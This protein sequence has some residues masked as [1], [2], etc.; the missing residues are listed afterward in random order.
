MLMEQHF[1]FE[2]LTLGVGRSSRARNVFA[3][4]ELATEEAKQ[5]ASSRD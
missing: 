3:D 4:L 1:Q 2:M 5:K